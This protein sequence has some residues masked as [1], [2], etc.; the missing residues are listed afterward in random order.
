MESE[1]CVELLDTDVFMKVSVTGGSEH[2]QKHRQGQR[3]RTDSAFQ[4][5]E[6]TLQ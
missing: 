4:Q 3:P 2:R 1:A 5:S 6:R